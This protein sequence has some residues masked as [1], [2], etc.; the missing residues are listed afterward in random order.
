MGS[1]SHL[2]PFPDDVPTAP[3]LRLSYQKIAAADEREIDRLF[4]ASKDTGFFYLDLSG[5]ADCQPL[6]ENV[7]GLFDLADPLFNTSLEDKS[8]HLINY[9]TSRLS[10]FVF[11]SI[12]KGQV[13]GFVDQI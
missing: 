4:A 10:G 11:Q 7:N 9:N 5:S 3:L 1:C 6:L 12:N 13:L 8:K 2:P